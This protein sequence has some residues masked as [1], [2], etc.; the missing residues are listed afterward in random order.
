MDSVPALLDYSLVGLYF[1]ALILVGWYFRREQP[2]GGD[3]LFA[4]Q[5]LGAVPLGLSLA[6]VAVA[7]GGFVDVAGEAYGAGF[8]V[9]AM[10]LAI[11]CC[12][13][14]VAR[15][16]L[17]LYY[18]LGIDSIYDYLEL[19]FDA[20][21]R[22]VASL[23]FALWRVTWLAVI[24]YAPCKVL[25]ELA[26]FPIDPLFLLVVTGMVTTVYTLWG[27]LKAVVWGAVLQTA[28][29]GVGLALLVI[30]ISS[31]LSAGPARVLEIARALGRAD[32]VGVSPAHPDPWPV[33][34][35]FPL[36]A[37]AALALFVADQIT[38]QRYLAARTLPE[39]RKSLAWTCVVVTL[40]CGTLLYVGLALLAF[41]QESPQAMRPIWVANV[42]HQTHRSVTD[43]QGVP[44]IAWSREAVTPDNI[45]GLVADRR[46]LRP[47]TH[48]PFTDSEGLVV[49]SDG[50]EQISIRQL[51]MRK[52]PPAG[53]GQGEFILNVRALA[54]LGP[55]FAASQTAPGVTGCVLAA[56]LAASMSCVS[57]G[58]HALA[59]FW[60]V[61]SRRRKSQGAPLR[62]TVE[63]S[64]GRRSI[65]VAGVLVTLLSLALARWHDH[66]GLFVSAASALAGPL[67]AVFLLGI[68]TRRT[69]STGAWSTLLIGAIVALGGAVISGGLDAPR[70]SGVG[71]AGRSMLWPLAAGFFCAAAWGYLASLVLGK[72]KPHAE[73]RGLVIG[74][75]SLGRR[76][77]EEASIAIPD[78]FD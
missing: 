9:L 60:V 61:S 51:A 37:L 22:V 26:G 18:R 47:N 24:A 41:Y 34:E 73:L 38:A 31:Q 54:E 7:V 23:M 10:P 12:L 40:L 71:E 5:S 21:T 53:L 2:T 50:A 56:V 13:P 33:W 28:V 19:R 32:V 4:R 65:F 15:T 3:F 70:G 14:L 63:L 78:S 8:R 59:T 36:W 48:E 49:D 58:I 11:C 67:L 46:L 42:D 29:M 74:L 62:G 57:A 6:V 20:R 64:A 75:G 45:D 17:P 35:A 39:A 68:L 44:L 55:H 76:E 72:R 77:P 27:G 52:P 43:D 25:I 30:T 66:L 69:T 1:F 16:V